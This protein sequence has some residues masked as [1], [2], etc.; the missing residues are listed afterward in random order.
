MSP[1]VR[2]S[3]A[4][5][6][7]RRMRYRLQ[8][9][10]R[11]LALYWCAIL[12]SDMFALYFLPIYVFQLHLRRSI[13]RDYNAI[14]FRSPSQKRQTV[15]VSGIPTSTTT[16]TIPLSPTSA[17]STMILSHLR[18]NLRTRLK[19]RWLLCHFFPILR[20]PGMRPRCRRAM[21]SLCDAITTTIRSCIY[22]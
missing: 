13:M 20:R 8:S 5:K 3:C 4:L 10:Y 2:I 17:A 14:R 16:I 7:I 22:Q 9:L 6:P 12:A 18:L 19:Q 21:L 11:L 1:R 15:S